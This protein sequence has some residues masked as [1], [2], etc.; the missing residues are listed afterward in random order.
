MKESI[1]NVEF[2]LQELSLRSIEMIDRAPIHDLICLMY[3][4]YDGL[5]PSCERLILKTFIEKLEEI[6]K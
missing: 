3:E 1:K 6:I 2:A 5:P 4:A